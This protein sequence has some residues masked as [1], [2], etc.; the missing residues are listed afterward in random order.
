VWLGYQTEMVRYA[1]DQ[2]VAA[3]RIPALIDVP[4]EGNV[5]HLMTAAETVKIT[6]PQIAA[7]DAKVTAEVLH[8]LSLGLE[9]FIQH[10]VL[11][12]EAAR[13][14]GRKAWEEFMGIPYTP[15]LDAED[16]DTD[17][18]AT[19]VDDAGGGTPPLLAAV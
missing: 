7:A 16:A 18:I 3:G 1:V 15:E 17:D 6:G 12:K 13:V 9:K 8:R 11:S 19:A 10:G 5:T 4:G 14:A 2:A